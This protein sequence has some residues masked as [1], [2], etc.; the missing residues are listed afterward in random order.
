[1]QRV[2]G[3]TCVCARNTNEDVSPVGG[4]GDSG[5][6]LELPDRLGGLRDGGAFGERHCG[7]FLCVYWGWWMMEKMGWQRNGGVEGG[8]GGGGGL[9]SGRGD[10]GY[11]VRTLW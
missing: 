7:L 4:Q 8:E 9:Y 3:G 5:F 10:L 2:G 6:G 11:D 1:M